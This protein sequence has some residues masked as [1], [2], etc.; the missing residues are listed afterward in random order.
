[1]TMPITRAD[2]N[3]T[4]ML[5]NGG[6]GVETIDNSFTEKKCYRTYA[7]LFPQ[8]KPSASSPFALS[9]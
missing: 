6:T 4:T 8:Q 1:M 5:L 3:W 9:L 7:A 2:A